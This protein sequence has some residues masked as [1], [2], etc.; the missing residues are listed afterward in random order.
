[1][2]ISQSIILICWT[3]FIIYWLANWRNV[4]PAL[5]KKHHTG[6]IRGIILVIIAILLLNRFILHNA[7]HLPS[8][9]LDWR[10]C[11][12]HS[13][14]SASSQWLV[15]QI[16]SVG[17]AILGLTIAIIARKTLAA[18]WSPTLDLKK[19]HE[20]I[21]T[22]IYNYIR[23]PIYTGVLL[24]LLATLLVFPTPFEF[25]ILLVLTAAFLYR[26]KR[27]EDLM[28]KTFPKEYPAYKKKTKA[29][30]PFIY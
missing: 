8:C 13:I 19:G 27:E 6:L 23:H 4:K 25:F 29:L 7:I 28:T 30:I 16:I 24:M 20:L 2:S 18:N 12:L 10:G 14:P 22:G 17:L 21:T 26:I 11:H 15:F 1:M 3:I 5:E 9:Q